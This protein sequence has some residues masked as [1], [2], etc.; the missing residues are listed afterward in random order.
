[1]V[2]K[3]AEKILD[4][5]LDVGIDVESTSTSSDR[6]VI[7]EAVDILE[8]CL[9]HEEEPLAAKFLIKYKE[10]RTPQVKAKLRPW[11]EE[12]LPI[13]GYV[14]INDLPNMPVDLT[15]CTDEEIRRFHSI[16]NAYFV[17]TSYLVM[18]QEIKVNNSKLAHKQFFN[19]ELLM[20]DPFYREGNRAPKE[21]TKQIIE[22][23]AYQNEKLVASQSNL[24]EDE[25][26]LSALK[27]LRDIYENNCT[28]LSRESTMRFSEHKHG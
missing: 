15:T 20:I 11:Q 8:D 22:A 14:D 26:D 6:D 13:P 27:S 2:I 24:Q 9:H 1:M 17:R 23:E 21:K 4:I 12:D 19:R 25:N 28:R 18:L 10:F 7:A 3:D 16:F 5:A